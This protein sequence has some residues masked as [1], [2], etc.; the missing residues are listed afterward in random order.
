[1]LLYNSGGVYKQCDAAGE[2][3]YKAEIPVQ[4][5]HSSDVQVGKLVQVHLKWLTTTIQ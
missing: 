4:E 2:W 1:M 5:R 3:K